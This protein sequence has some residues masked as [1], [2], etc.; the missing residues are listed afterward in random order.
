MGARLWVTRETTRAKSRSFSEP[1]SF[2][3]PSLPRSQVRDGFLVSASVQPQISKEREGVVWCTIPRACPSPACGRGALLRHAFVALRAMWLPVRCRG[4]ALHVVMVDSCY[5]VAPGSPQD[6]QFDRDAYLQSLANE[7]LLAMRASVASS[8]ASHVPHW[9]A[10]CRSTT[11]PV[12]MTPVRA[13][14][15]ACALGP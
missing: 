4:S 7:V 12:S 3:N 15:S 10:R 5:R 13:H 1:A 8:A 11:R 9:Q 14:R 6:S 2:R